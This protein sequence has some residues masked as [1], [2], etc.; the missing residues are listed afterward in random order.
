MQKAHTR[1]LFLIALLSIVAI[2]S[3]LFFK[4]KTSDRNVLAELKDLKKP[5]VLLITVDTTRADHLPAYG[6]KKIKTPNIDALANEGILFRQ[7]ATTSPLTLPAHCS[8][9]T[10][11]YPTYHGVRINGNTALS[12]ENLTL[13]EAFSKN[14]YQ[15]GA[16]VGAFVLDGRWGL[17]QGFDHYDDQFDLKKFKKLDLGLVQ[18]PGNEIVDAAL[19]WLEDQKDKPF[20]AWLH[21]YDPHTPYAPPDRYKPESNSMIGLYDGEIAYMDEQIGRCLMW[22]QR[23]GLKEKTIVALIGDH[24]EGLGDHGEKTHGYFIYDY[25]VHVPFI[26]SAPA[27]GA[28]GVEIPS[29]VRTIDLYP[30]LLQASGISISKNVQGTSL[31]SL[32]QDGGRSSDRFYAYSESM[33]PSI[34]YG[35]SPLL[36]LRTSKFKFIDAPRKEFYDLKN[37]PTEQNDVHEANSKT[38]ADYEKTLKKVVQETSEGAPGAHVANLDSE[39]VERLAALGYI[40]AAVAT[41]PAGDPH[42]LIDPKDRLTVHEAIQEAGE[43]TNNDQN[44]EAAAV[45]EKILKEDPENPQARLLL[46]GSYVELK[47]PEEAASLLRSLL[48][49]DPN[50]VRA[51]V[52]LANILQDEGKSDE[53]IVLC[54]KAVEVD[55]RNSQA[56]GLMGQA[57]MDMAN[58]K[59]ALPWLKKA[60]DIQPK[61]TQNQLNYVACLIGL[62]RYEEAEKSLNA[63]LGE[64]PKFPLAH[65]H[66]GLLYEEQGKLQESY[67]EYEKE[68]EFYPD[69]FVARFNLGRLQLRR[70]DK[71]GYMAQMREVVR[72]APQNS[73]G[74]LFLARGLLQ[75]NADTNEI[76]NLTEK[77]LSLAK[78]P[79]HKAMGYFLLADIYNR[80]NQPQQVR[81]ALASANQYKAQIRQ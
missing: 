44:Q 76:L 4:R 64:H 28:T 72:T 17:N 15:T 23:K 61:L 19:V 69:C 20:F 33:A 10:G 35:W 3:L 75:Q 67:R 2:S 58:F 42:A 73:M 43:L 74:Y 47:R 66:L 40:G 31:W 53:V 13:A 59:E 65:F 54:K 77:G 79:A 80:K 27:K 41:K 34:Q 78:N 51:L 12:S 36:S 8:I 49:E 1:G 37:D 52:C 32:I 50:N 81:Q 22:L 18:R 63:I 60:V 26:L 9:F 29:Q 7:C 30:T 11:T 48:E 45:L 56:L 68:L 46:A 21:F 62:K 39:T 6:Y 16:F 24:G 38:F 70:G 55:E 5:N 71:E 57:Y 14:G 25:A